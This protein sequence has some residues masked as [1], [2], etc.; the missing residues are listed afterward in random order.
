MGET[1][2]EKYTKGWKGGMPETPCGAGSTIGNTELQRKWIPKLIRKY[3]IKSIADIGAGDLNWIKK[4]KLPKKIEYTAYDLIP[5]RGNIER[6]D[7]INEVPPKVDLI[8]CLWV[9]NHMSLEHREAA[10][11]NLKASG[12]KYLLITDRFDWLHLC[13]MDFEEQLILNKKNKYI[14]L[15]KN[16]CLV[17]DL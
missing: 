15:I 1:Q 8:M 10:I 14:G 3:K 11:K 4:T 17:N 9:V 16:D 12:S 7:I 13:G 6:F 5:R 2:L